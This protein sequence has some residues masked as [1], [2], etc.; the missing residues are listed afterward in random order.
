MLSGLSLIGPVV[1]IVGPF[2]DDNFDLAVGLGAIALS[3]WWWYDLS[4]WPTGWVYW[5]EHGILMPHRWRVPRFFRWDDVAHLWPWDSEA[6]DPVTSV[7]T[8]SH[9]CD[10]E[11]TGGSRIR[12]G[13]GCIGDKVEATLTKML[14]Q[15]RL[16]QLR[17]EG[18]A[19]FGPITIEPTGL[20]AGSE[21]IGWDDIAVVD[22]G[23]TRLQVLDGDRQVRVSGRTKRIPE[24][25][26][27]L[28][29]VADHGVAVRWEPLD[30]G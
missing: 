5:C 17:T 19:E 2:D 20:R 30:G 8:Y 23:S 21:V 9:G 13:E 27:L 10:V 18:R 16:E 14:R 15:R 25:A 7:P 24:L 26:V 28:R 12:F 1:L 29:I 6:I 11:L 4:H 3:L 22:V